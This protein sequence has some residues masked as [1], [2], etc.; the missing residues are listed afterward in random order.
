MIHFRRL[1]K[2][3][4]DIKEY[5][6]DAQK[7]FCDLSIGMKYM[8]RDVYVVEY[9][10]VNDTL[11]MKETANEYANVFY[12]P[13]G[14]DVLGALELIE[15]HCLKNNIP[16]VFGCVDNQTV[17]FLH[18]RYHEIEVVNERDWSDYFYLSEK[19]KTYSGKKLG[20]QRNHVNKFKKLYPN[21]KFKAVLETDV[22]RIKEFINEYEK[23]KVLSEGAKEESVLLMDYVENMFWLGQVAGY[24]E[25]DGK[26]IALSVGEVVGD[27]L[28]VHVEKALT[29]YQG[30]YPVMASEFAKAFA[31]DGVKYI[32]REEDC[33][34][35]GLRTSKLQY[36]P[37]EIKDKNI[38][39]VKTLFDKI[40]SPILIETEQLIITDIEEKDKED[41]AK[42]Y[43]D[44]EL[45]KWWGYDY[46]EDL[47]G[48]EPTP[49]YFYNFQK[50]LKEIKEEYALAVKKDGK[51]IGEL[52]L[53][54][55]DYFGGIEIGFRFFK[56]YQGKGYATKSAKALKDY[57]FNKLKANRVKSRCFKEN[58]PSAR[59]I[60]RLGLEKTHQSSTHYFFAQEK[61]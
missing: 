29:R 9:A 30:A 35:I 33:G 34:E 21:Y 15:K 24:I 20:G 27:T 22:D 2:N 38:V 17:E 23:S 32:N 44:D 14:K 39:K 13:I 3:T 36:Q 11:I 49:E 43:L 6:K 5:L 28:I 52:V 4:L 59:L 48:S 50:K 16:L 8:W 57:C 45:N 53:H 47:N 60:L 37:I 10:V 31:G 18:K 61:F 19:F 56:N 46:R 54:N 41:Y 58:E 55:F 42:L 12:V 51:M 25:V 1:E 7:P 26:I 40:N